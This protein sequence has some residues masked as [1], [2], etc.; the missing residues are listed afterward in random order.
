MTTF[1]LIR[2]GESEGNI[3]L[4]VTDPALTQDGINQVLE[5]KQKL[6]SIQFTSFYSSHKRRTIQSA[7]IFT[8][9]QQEIIIN[10]SLTEIKGPKLGKINSDQNTLKELESSFWSLSEVEKWNF[11]TTKTDDE[12]AKEGYRRF[13]NTLTKISQKITTGNIAIFS[14]GFILRV[15][16]IGLK[17]YTFSQIGHKGSL[18]NCGYLILDWN[19]P[20]N[21]NL[22]ELVGIVTKD[23][24]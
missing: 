7:L 20:E 3:G 12:S 4:D 8:D 1:Y 2:H 13:T 21:F 5:L 14:H 10:P 22:K 23:D 6:S 15:L 11:K 9:N 16:L 18:K 19:S 17:K 24:H